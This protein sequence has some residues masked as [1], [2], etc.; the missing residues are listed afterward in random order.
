MIKTY[1]SPRTI[2]VLAVRLRRPASPGWMK[3]N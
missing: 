2:A 3:L 1:P